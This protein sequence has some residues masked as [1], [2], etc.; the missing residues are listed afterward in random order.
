MPLP[1]ETVTVLDFTQIMA[2]P[3]A[4]RQLSLMGATVIK[5]EPRGHG[6]VM[7]P[8]MAT[9]AAAEHGFSP[10]HQYLNPGKRSLALD[11]KKD[12]GVEIAQKLATRADV[13][14]E[15]F[16][17]S[18]MARFGLDAATVRRDNPSVVYCSISGYG[19]EGP[20]AELAAYD[21]PLQADSGLMSVNGF[22]DGP[23][24]R[25]GVMAIDM[26]VGANAAS[27]IL[28]GLYRRK[29][30][31][32]GQVIDISMFETALHLLTPQVVS[33]TNEG[34]E[35]GRNGNNTAANLPTDNLF[36][37]GDGDLLITA[38]NDGQIKTLFQVLG[39]DEMAGSAATATPEARRENADLIHEK[40]S[41]ALAADSAVEW[42]AKLR[43]AGVPCARVRT[44]P[45]V[46]D[47]PQVGVNE[48][49][50]ETESFADLGIPAATV[51]AAGYRADTDGPAIRPAPLLSADAEEILGELGYSGAEIEAL[52]TEEVI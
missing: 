46:L 39:L 25:L 27:A 8:M 1:L 20:K 35:M 34:A 6:D 19:R 49:L 7:R 13:I 22:P 36:R 44:V 29:E 48:L 11:L 41:L 14:V 30:T 50:K 23:P 3:M 33:F 40:V 45:E 31:G 24:T 4:T 12:A 43:E 52:R 18:V 2:G 16:R 47:D 5:V 10:L 37:T 26:L 38:I 9:G 42:E 21:G 32:E 15:N 28:G 17:P 51:P